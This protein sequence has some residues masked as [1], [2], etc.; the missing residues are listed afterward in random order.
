VISSLFIVAFVLADGLVRGNSLA[1]AAPWRAGLLAA[2]I[3]SGLIV[4][5][6][7]GHF[8]AA[9]MGIV[10]VLGAMLVSDAFHHIGGLGLPAM[11]LYAGAFAWQRVV[12]RD[13]RPGFAWAGAILSAL[14]LLVVISG[15]LPPNGAWNRNVIA[16]TLVALLP[17]A[18]SLWSSHPVRKWG[19]VALSL[20]AIG[21][22]VSRGAYMGS[23][24]AMLV[25][26][27]EQVRFT[28]WTW[29]ALGVSAPVALWGLTAL[30]PVQSVERLYF[31]RSA[32]EQWWTTSPLFGVGPGQLLVT[33]PG[34]SLPDYHAHCA[35]VSFVSQVGLA[36][37]G[38]LGAALGAARRE[39]GHGWQRW[40]LATLAAV[41]VHSLVDEPLTW[42][43][44]GLIVALVM[45]SSRMALS[46]LHCV[47][48]KL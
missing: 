44:T 4:L 27:S 14:V 40:Q 43:P 15:R 11:V 22:T 31:I 21:A 2:L 13:W 42:W 30:R 12:Q 24:A 6:I 29:A 16:G 3:V 25:L 32:V 7:K 18:W 37:G 47:Q 41:A 8:D 39:I 5:G 33:A 26:I 48:G 46:P 35:V 45:G 36:G 38:V 19:A 10:G 28:R 34:K 9:T 23:V 17:A 20:A 1:W